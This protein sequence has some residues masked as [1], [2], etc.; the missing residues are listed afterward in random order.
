MECYSLETGLV[1]FELTGQSIVSE[2]K[3]L[4]LITVRVSVITPMEK[5][6]RVQDTRM[7]R[8]K[9]ALPATIDLIRPRVAR[10]RENVSSYWVYGHRGSVLF[11][12][13]VDSP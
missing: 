13:S 11:L 7:P 5:E 4:Y 6:Y 3:P 2:A 9:G 1:M 10:L 8:E 12:T